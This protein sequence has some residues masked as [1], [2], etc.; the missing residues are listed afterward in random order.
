MHG[1]SGRALGKW[2][3]GLFVCCEDSGVCCYQMFCPCLSY[4]SLID[5][6]RTEGN[7]ALLGGQNQKMMEW[8]LGCCPGLFCGCPCQIYVEAGTRGDVRSIYRIPGDFFGDCCTQ[9][10]DGPQPK[11]QHCLRAFMIFPCELCSCFPC[12]VKQHNK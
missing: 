1:T 2:H 7:R 3:D 4:Y 6:G 8:C 12:L 11:Q 9:L 5:K 10:T